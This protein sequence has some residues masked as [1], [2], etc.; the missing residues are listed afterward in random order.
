LS[1]PLV[2]IPKNVPRSMKAVLFALRWYL[3]AIFALGLLGLV[4][5]TLLLISL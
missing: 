3:A 1:K 2:G 4:V 5:W